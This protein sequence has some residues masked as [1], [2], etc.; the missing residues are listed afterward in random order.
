MTLPNFLHIGINKAASS[1]LWRVCQQHPD[2][3]VPE[4]PDNVNFWSF[5]VPCG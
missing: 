5:R 1:W 3:Y 2:I 4:M